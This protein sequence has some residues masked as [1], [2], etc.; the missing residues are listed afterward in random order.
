MSSQKISLKRFKWKI[1][2][3]LRPENI[4]ALW[5][6]CKQGIL[7]FEYEINPEIILPKSEVRARNSKNLDFPNFIKLT[8]PKIIAMVGNHLKSTTVKGAIG[9]GIFLGN[10]EILF[11]NSKKS[12]PM[13]STLIDWREWWLSTNKRSP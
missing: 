2:P 9:K 7:S 3:W 5:L 4:Y 1:A 6:Y 13:M 10:I 12:I 8:D 11:E